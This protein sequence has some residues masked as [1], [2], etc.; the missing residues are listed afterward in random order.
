MLRRL[1]KAFSAAEKQPERSTELNELREA[2][3]E[4]QHAF[5]TVEFE[6]TEMYEKFNTL[7]AR[8][9]KRVKAEANGTAT[10]GSQELTYAER[11]AIARAKHGNPF[12][13]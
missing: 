3:S 9:S 6:W 7:H 5:K 10:A 1:L 13:R 4:L 11:L 12:Q 8:L 2:V